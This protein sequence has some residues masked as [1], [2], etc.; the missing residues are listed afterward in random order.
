[1]AESGF[2]KSSEESPEELEM[3]NQ[4]EKNRESRHES[5]RQD[6]WKV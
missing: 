5:S 6:L 1:M 3:F 2:Q 4:G